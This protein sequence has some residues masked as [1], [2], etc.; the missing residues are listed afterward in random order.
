MDSVILQSLKKFLL[1][2]KRKDAATKNKLLI[3]QHSIN[4]ILQMTK[5]PMKQQSKVSILACTKTNS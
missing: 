5:T 4:K 3:F 1:Q 2:Q